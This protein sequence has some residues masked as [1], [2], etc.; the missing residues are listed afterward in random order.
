MFPPIISSTKAT[1]SAAP[2]SI[3][4]RDGPAKGFLN[5]VWS[6]K[7]DVARDAPHN[8]AVITWGSRRL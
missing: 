6:N 8:I 7:P 1:P 4:N 2:A 5:V 3:P